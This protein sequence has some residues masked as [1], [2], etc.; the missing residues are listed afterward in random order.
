VRQA[1]LKTIQREQVAAR[2]IL[3]EHRR[4]CSVCQAKGMPD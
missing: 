3:I 4:N 1:R 2:E